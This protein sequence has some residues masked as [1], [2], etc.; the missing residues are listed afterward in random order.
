MCWLGRLC[1][2]GRFA[3]GSLLGRFAAGSLFAALL[4]FDRPSRGQGSAGEEAAS[5]QGP[6]P[7]SLRVDV[8]RRDVD[9]TV[10]GSGNL[11][12]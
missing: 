7:P 2:L 6:Y 4:M 12:R 5:E 10:R 3:A 11:P 8:R 1:W 9:D